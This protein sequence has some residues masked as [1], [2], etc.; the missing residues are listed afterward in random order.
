MDRLA[1][2]FSLSTWNVEPGDEAIGPVACVSRVSAPA[3]PSHTP[4]ACSGDAQWLIDY[5]TAEAALYGRR[6]V[7]DRFPYEI[8]RN[9]RDAS[10][11]YV[12]YIPPRGV[13]L[14][15]LLARYIRA[16]MR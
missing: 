15:R 10:D 2:A 9:P 16:L 13:P 7:H 11:N 5:P 1:R 6:D 4:S 8:S 14:P 12:R 3:E